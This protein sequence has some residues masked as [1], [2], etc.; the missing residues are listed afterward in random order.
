MKKYILFFLAAV[1]M[2]N[3][4][5]AEFKIGATFE[6]NAN[7]YNGSVKSTT[8]NGKT[9]TDQEHVAVSGYDF[10]NTNI[11]FSFDW[12]DLIGFQVKMSLPNDLINITYAGGFKFDDTF[13]WFKLGNWFKGQV[14]VFDRGLVNKANSVIDDWEYGV[15][16]AANSLDVNQRT[17]L[18]RNM[19]LD[20]YMGPVAL[21]I[22]LLQGAT[23][24]SPLFKYTSKDKDST[25]YGGEELLIHPGLRISGDVADKA[26]I[27]GTF[28]INFLRQSPKGWDPTVSNPETTATS[29]K[30]GLFGDI[31]AVKDLVLAVGYSGTIVANEK[32]TGANSYNAISDI[33]N[34]AE[35]RAEYKG[36]PGWTIA[37]HN[38]IGGGTAIGKSIDN[39]G[40][41][42]DGYKSFSAWD[43]VGFTYTFD[44]GVKIWCV[45][46]N[47]FHR[48]D[49]GGAQRTIETENKFAIKPA[50]GYN[51]TEN[52]FAKVG[53]TLGVNYKITTVDSKETEKVLEIAPSIPIT[54]SLKF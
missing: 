25:A 11:L 9:T 10:H 33:Y 54:L 6:G 13:G 42:S 53:F 8:K 4:A 35:L 16:S 26:K 52:F 28:D 45:A 23:V 15:V 37:T 51:F 46:T 17:D 19:I 49:K 43:A 18:L 36:F 22:G 24:A 48:T 3:A 1:F 27:V 47:Q 14:G 7:L 39:T 5:F 31:F 20:F 40:K 2:A 21:E 50:V 34:F 29:M 12:K 41:I 44:S 30:Y 38:K 32:Y